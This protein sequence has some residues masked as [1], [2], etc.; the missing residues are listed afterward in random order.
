MNERERVKAFA[1]LQINTSDEV[2]HHRKYSKNILDSGVVIIG[3]YLAIYFLGM[4]TIGRLNNFTLT[5]TLIESTNFDVKQ[6]DDK[7]TVRPIRVNVCD[8]VRSKVRKVVRVKQI[9]RWLGPG[10]NEFRFDGLKS[11]MNLVRIG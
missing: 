1:T 5:S 4:Q 10:K 8:R 3:F 11:E 9:K 2:T 7:Y 6:I